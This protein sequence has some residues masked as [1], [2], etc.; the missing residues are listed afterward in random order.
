VAFLVEVVVDLAMDCGE[1]LQTLPPPEGKHL[2]FPSSEWLVADF[3][4][5]DQV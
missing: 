1:F 2:P 3:G 5:V 4:A